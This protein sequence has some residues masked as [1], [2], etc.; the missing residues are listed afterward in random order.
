MYEDDGGRRVTIYVR[1][2]QGK[3]TAFR[4]SGNRD[5]STFYWIDAP[6]AYAL[7]GGIPRQ[8]LLG[9]AHTVYEDL[10]R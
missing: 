9:L 1:P 3:E 6:F 7:A 4:F 2:Q 8:D 10:V 5:I